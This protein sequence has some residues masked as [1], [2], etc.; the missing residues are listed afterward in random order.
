M[1]GM[2]VLTQIQNRGPFFDDII[3]VALKDQEGTYKTFLSPIKAMKTWKLTDLKLGPKLIF[4]VIFIL[5]QGDKD[6]SAVLFISHAHKVPVRTTYIS[7]AVLWT[8]PV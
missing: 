4:S 5:K 8:V 6:C 1:L 2:F 7:L 3:P